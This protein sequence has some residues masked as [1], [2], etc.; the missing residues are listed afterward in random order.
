MELWQE[1]EVRAAVES[2]GDETEGRWATFT[3]ERVFR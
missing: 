3:G 1:H 2:A